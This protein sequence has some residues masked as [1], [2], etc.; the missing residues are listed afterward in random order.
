M[1]VCTLDTT[2]RQHIP[3]YYKYMSSTYLVIHFKIEMKLTG[4]KW[5]S[6]LKV[7]FSFLASQDAL[8]VMGVS[9][10]LSESWLADLTDV[11]LASD[12]T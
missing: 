8:E 9:D 1:C 5:R 6:Q 7:R 2:I 10:W 3:S 11:T 12:D 4:K